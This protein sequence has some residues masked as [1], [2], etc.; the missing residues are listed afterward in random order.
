MRDQVK[1]EKDKLVDLAD[2]YLSKH[3]ELSPEAKQ[4]LFKELEHQRERFCKVKKV[5]VEEEL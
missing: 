3:E 4:A 2:C 5:K 1:I